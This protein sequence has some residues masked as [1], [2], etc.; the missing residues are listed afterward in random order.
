MQQRRVVREEHEHGASVFAD[1]EGS[2]PGGVF[3]HVGD[4]DAS[5][6]RFGQA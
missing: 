6:A 5:A 4:A 2:L 3:R 1:A